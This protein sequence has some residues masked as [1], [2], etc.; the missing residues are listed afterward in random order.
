[1]TDVYIKIKTWQFLGL[2]EIIKAKGITAFEAG[3]LV[4][5]SVT[6][7]PYTS[8]FVSPFFSLACVLGYLHLYCRNRTDASEGG[9]LIHSKCWR[10]RPWS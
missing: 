8:H 5:G 3:V 4:R 1:M 7:P 9:K 10:C 6:L 2:D